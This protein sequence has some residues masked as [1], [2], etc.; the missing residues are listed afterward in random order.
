M[1]RVKWR[2]R[3]AKW[4]RRKWDCSSDQRELAQVFDTGYLEQRRALI[5]RFGVPPNKIF[6]QSR[7]SSGA[8][9]G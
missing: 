5:I 8:S 7:A 3:L 4:I 1:V 2:L 6:V 9:I